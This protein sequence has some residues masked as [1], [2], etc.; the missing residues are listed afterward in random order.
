[1]EVE[2][3]CEAFGLGAPAGPLSYVGRGELGR[4][5]RLVTADGSWAVKE[6]E[7]F[8]PTV[9][10]ADAN[11]EL[12]ESMLAAGVHL[13]RPRRT[14]DGHGLVENVRVYEWLDMTPV[15]VGDPSGDECVAETLARIHLYAPPTD[16]T[17][18]PWYCEAPSRNVW[19]GLIGAASGTW[20]APVIAALV[21]ELSDVPPPDHSPTRFCHLDVCPENVFFSDGRLIV[22]DWENAGPAATLQDLGSTLWDFGRGDIGRTRA[23]VDHY[24][25]HDGR[26]ETL[27]ESV[28]DTARV[29]YANLVDFHARRARDPTFTPEAHARAERALHGLLARPLTRR[30]VSDLVA[31]SS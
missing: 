18:D 21:P 30:L 28:F 26:V 8:V 13:P 24:R 15:K 25:R 31:A 9:D 27:D 12:Q 19:D 11:V 7:L 14:V 23:F 17:P 2:A 16:L 10:E 6:I 5:S 20:W 1:V 3:I 22:I 4:V 29:V